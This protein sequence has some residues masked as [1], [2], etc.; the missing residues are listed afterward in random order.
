MHTRSTLLSASAGR[1]RMGYAIFREGRLIYHGLTELRRFHTERELK[2]TV[3][4]FLTKV[5]SRFQVEEVAVRGLI[6]QQQENVLLL[7][8]FDQIVANCARDHVPLT[9]YAG[10]YVNQ[11]FCEPGQRPTKEKMIQ[12][13]LGRYPHFKA[14]Y[15]SDRDWNGRYYIHLFQAVAVGAVHIKEQKENEL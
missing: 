11:Q 13:I 1:H 10:R 14:K 5:T 3:D 4:R 7:A 2:D 8:V 12:A 6:E 9:L 15:R